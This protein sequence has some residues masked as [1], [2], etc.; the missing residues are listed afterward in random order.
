MIKIDGAIISKDTDKGEKR[1]LKRFSCLKIKYQKIST[2]AIFV[3]K[4]MTRNYDK[5]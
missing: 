1:G 3:K 2:P 4:L 5:F